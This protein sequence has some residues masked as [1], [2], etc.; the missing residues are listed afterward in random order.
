M[1][2]QLIGVPLELAISPDEEKALGIYWDVKKDD[3]MSS[4]IFVRVLEK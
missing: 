2:E 1:P 4:P 3:F